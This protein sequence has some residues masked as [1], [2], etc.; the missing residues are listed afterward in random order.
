MAKSTKLKEFIANVKT[1][2]LM[3]TSRYSVLM[4]TPTSIQGKQKADV[5]KILLFCSDLQLPGLNIITAQNRTFGEVREAPYD[6]IYDNV[7]LTFYVDQNMDVK[8][9]FDSWINSIQRPDTRTFE[10]YK[11]YITEMYIQVEDARDDS[12]YLVILHEAYPKSLSPIQLGY[13]NKEVM[14]LQV[15]MN[16]RNWTYYKIAASTKAEPGAWDSL[17]KLPT[18]NNREIGDYFGNNSGFQSN[19]NQLP[20]V[21]NYPTG[22]TDKLSFF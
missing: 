13:D 22:I 10:Y 8:E 7:N 9:Y 5:R 20:E 21:Q 16:Y 19:A 15:S 11:N 17:F 4:Q 14:K 6:R 12:R 2:G 1:G 18:I 3:K